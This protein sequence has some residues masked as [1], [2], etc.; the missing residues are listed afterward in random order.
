MVG[1]VKAPPSEIVAVPI[2]IE[3]TVV[4]EPVNGK[5]PETVPEL[6]LTSPADAILKTFLPFSVAEA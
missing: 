5:E 2:E 4:S 3:L 6:R 1:L